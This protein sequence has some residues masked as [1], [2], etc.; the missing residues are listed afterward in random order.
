MSRTVK[1]LISE[2]P[3]SLKRLVKMT[4]FRPKFVEVTF[5]VG[6]ASVHR[7]WRTGSV[8]SLGKK[9][10][11][12][13]ES[14]MGSDGES[15]NSTEDMYSLPTAMAVPACGRGTKN[16]VRIF[17]GNLKEYSSLLSR[18]STTQI[19]S[20]LMSVLVDDSLARECTSVPLRADLVASFDHTPKSVIKFTGLPTG[21]AS[22]WV[23]ESDAERVLAHW[24]GYVAQKEM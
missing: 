10:S 20:N 2:L 12:V 8:Y 5:S 9:I 11:S 14:Y 18:E 15:N 17:V 24:N 3:E 7:Y 16:D 21:A 23:S 13:D 1:Y 22:M 19:S 4:G 6:P